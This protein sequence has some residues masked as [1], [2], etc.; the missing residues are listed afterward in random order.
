MSNIVNCMVPARMGSQRVKNKNI[1]SLNGKPLITY[2]LNS[3]SKSKKLFNNIYLN[4][5]SKKIKRY[6]NDFGFNFYHRNK[7]LSTNKSTNDE[8][9]YDFIKNVRSNYLVQILPTSPF[10]SHKD[11]YNFVNFLLHKNLI[12]LFQ[13]LIIK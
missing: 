1:K 12:H 11:I 3:I 9:A 8:F 13:L 2:V 10:L 6:A 5:E 4:S 7:S